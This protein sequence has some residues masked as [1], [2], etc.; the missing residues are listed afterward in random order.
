MMGRSEI[1][2]GLSTLLEQH[3]DKQTCVYG[4]EVSI[5]PLGRCRPDYLAVSA[6]YGKLATVASIERSE[7]I[8]YEIKSCLADFKSGHGVNEVGDNNWLVMPFEVIQS[9][10]Q[11]DLSGWGIAYPYPVSHGRVPD[12]ENLPTYEGQVEGWKLYW[13]CKAPSRFSQRP[14]P[15]MVYLWALLHSVNSGSGA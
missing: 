2:A 15:I 9:I 5:E 4:S 13:G 10:N 12:I 1:T 8:V 11:Y 3:L 14:M 7:V 6:N